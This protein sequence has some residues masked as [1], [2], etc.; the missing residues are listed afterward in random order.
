[1]EP[2]TLEKGGMHLKGIIM[3]FRAVRELVGKTSLLPSI[4]SFTDSDQSH[5][6]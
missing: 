3:H 4:E 5:Y 2:D 1:M 6:F